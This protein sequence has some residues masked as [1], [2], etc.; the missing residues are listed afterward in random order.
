MKYGFV[1][2]TTNTINGKQYIGR[3]AYRRPNWKSYLGSGKALKRAVAKY[4][5]ANFTRIVLEECDSLI[6]L[7]ACEEYYIQKYKK[8]GSV[9][10]NISS[11][12]NSTTGFSGKKH[13]ESYKAER[14]KKMMG[15]SVTI[16]VTN[17]AKSLGKIWGI[18]N[19]Q[20]LVFFKK[21]KHHLNAKS[22]TVEGICFDTIE[23]AAIFFNCSRYIIR[24]CNE[25][26]VTVNSLQ[27]NHTKLV[28]I[29]IEGHIIAYYDSF[30]DAK[31][32]TGVDQHSI[33]RCLLG[34]SKSGLAGGFKWQQLN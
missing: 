21:G 9:L 30:A 33:Q 29:D 5:R 26:N 2:L 17:H 4:G 14:S 8:D 32:C 13:T 1:Y 6:S 3:C 24:K 25:L 31:K 28:Q 20:N 7:T 23:E 11:R 18:K 12:S 15:H 34:I 27:Q 19:K 10:Y 16:N 22:V